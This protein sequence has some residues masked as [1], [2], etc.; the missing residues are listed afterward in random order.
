MIT[1][2][3][4]MQNIGRRVVYAPYRGEPEE[5]ILT[6]VST[7]G[8]WILVRYGADQYSKATAPGALEFADGD[9]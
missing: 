7:S 4:A 1:Q 8:A 9:S 6:G 3:E 2:R 5:G